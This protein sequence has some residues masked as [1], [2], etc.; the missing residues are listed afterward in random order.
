MTKTQS[1]LFEK[2]VY[3]GM[4]VFT[5]VGRPYEYYACML[6]SSILLVMTKLEVAERNICYD[7]GKR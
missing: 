4:F 3:H 7:I 1:I 6:L 2:G 5:D